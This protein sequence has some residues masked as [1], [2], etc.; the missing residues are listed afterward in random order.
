MKKKKRVVMMIMTIRGIT[1]LLHFPVKLTHFVVK[2]V[3]AK[4]LIEIQIK[5][6]NEHQGIYL[7]ILFNVILY[8]IIYNIIWYWYDININICVNLIFLVKIIYNAFMLFYWIYISNTYR[9]IRVL[10]IICFYCSTYIHSRN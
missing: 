4:L 6:L 2:N 9:N 10:T 3:K 8:N 5:S 1:I 7:F